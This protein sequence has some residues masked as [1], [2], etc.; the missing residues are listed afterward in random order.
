MDMEGSLR[1]WMSL[2]V[3]MARVAKILQTIQTSH[4]T[5]IGQTIQMQRYLGDLK[6]FDNSDGLD[7][8]GKS[9]GVNVLVG[10]A[11]EV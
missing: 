6:G 2:W 5:Y 4:V 10:L 8:I 7:A 3:W 1:A 9:D 11:S